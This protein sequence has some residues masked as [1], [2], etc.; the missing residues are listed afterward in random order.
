M[1][2]LKMRNNSLKLLTAPVFVPKCCIFIPCTKNIIIKTYGL[3]HSDELV[4][5]GK[6]LQPVPC[7]AV[8]LVVLRYLMAQK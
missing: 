6:G 8:T 7:G 1:A 5:H 2:I 3:L 4:H